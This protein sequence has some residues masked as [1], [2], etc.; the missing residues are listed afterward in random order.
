[1]IQDPGSSVQDPGSM[2]QDPGSMN[3]PLANISEDCA[4]VK[5]SIL[6]TKYPDPSRPTLHGKAEPRNLY[7][8]RGPRS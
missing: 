5:T 6:R 3:A 2:I 4:L 1:M 7:F 8:E